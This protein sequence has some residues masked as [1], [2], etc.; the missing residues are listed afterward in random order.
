MLLHAIFYPRYS[1]APMLTVTYLWIP[2]VVLGSL[3]QTARNAM[4]RGLTASLGTL[5]ASQVRFLFGFP[6]SLLFLVI[7][8]AVTRDSLPVIG[9]SFLPWLLLGALTQIGATAWMLTTMKSSSFVVSTAYIKTEPIQAAIFG[10]VFLS[11]PLTVWT[12][13]A[14]VIATSGVVITAVRPGMGRKFGD[15]KPTL[16]GLAS[17]AAFALSAVGYRGAILALSGTSFITASSFTLVMGLMLQTVL[18]A[19]YLLVFD[20]ANLWAILRLWRPSLL[21]GL[22]GAVASQFWFFSFALTSV[23][24]VRTLALIEV[25][26]AQAVSLYSF[27]QRVSLQEIVGIVLIMVGVGLLVAWR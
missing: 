21:A 5:G 25:P 6:F 10:F 23:A 4:Q 8:L 15:L 1:P 18:L 20:R 3:A 7:A 24:N 13:A 19:V 27:K 17:A 12:F 14:I 9:R 16:I 22:M 11:D 26:F 2:F